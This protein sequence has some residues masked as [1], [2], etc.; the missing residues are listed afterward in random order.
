M[1]SPES[2]WIVG[3]STPRQDLLPKVTGQPHFIHDLKI[4]GMLHARLVRPP[5]PSAKLI[6]LDEHSVKDI[7][8]LVK[9][10]QRGNF[11]GVVAEREEQAIQAAGQLKVEWQE[12]AAY[13]HLQ[14]LFTSLRNQPTEDS[15][16]VEKGD[17]KVYQLIS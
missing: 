5:N 3:K 6:S 8:G 14:D 16:L 11:I 13:P 1:K 9:V 15:L 17:F 4:P 10:F 2:Y 7:P 12:T